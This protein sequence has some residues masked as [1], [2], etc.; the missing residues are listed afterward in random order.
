MLRRGNRE[1]NVLFFMLRRGN[2]EENVESSQATPN[3]IE[4]HPGRSL[5]TGLNLRSRRGFLTRRS[6]GLL[7]CLEARRQGDR[8]GDWG[9]ASGEPGGAP[10]VLED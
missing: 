6:L 8:D 1:E 10:D 4:L 2:R 7:P 9:W 3:G 5:Q